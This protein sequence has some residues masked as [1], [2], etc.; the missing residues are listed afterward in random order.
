MINKSINIGGREL[1]I[2]SGK[3]ARQAS[4]SCIVKYGDTSLLVAVTAS[5]GIDEYRGFF[6]LSVEYRE[7][8]ML[9]EKFQVVISKEKGDQVK[10][11]YYLLA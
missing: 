5:K 3:L 2:E 9:A 7:R 1:T 10:K 6:P 11:K 4:G 8:F